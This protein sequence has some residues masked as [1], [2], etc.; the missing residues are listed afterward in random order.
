VVIVAAHAAFVIGVDTHKHTH[1]AAILDRGGRIR[2]QLEVTTD[3]AGLTRLLEHAH[4]IAPGPR[5]WAIEQTGSFGAGLTTLL[6]AAGE[7]VVEIDR[8]SRPARKNGAKDD[9]LDAIRAAREALTRAYLATP[10][11]RGTREA[12]RVLLTTRRAAITARTAAICQLKALV[13]TAPA[14]LRESLRGLS[15]P[16]LVRTCARLHVMSRHQPERRATVL[17]LRATARRIAFLTE[18][19]DELHGELG[20]LVRA[21]CPTLLGLPGLGVLTAAQLLVSWSHP[22]RVR[23]EAA[24]AAIA[25]AAPIL[26][27]SGQHTRHRLNRCGDRQLNRALHNI[28]LARMRCD[29]QTRHYVQRRQAEGRTT[30]EIQRCLKRAAARQLFRF[31]EANATPPTPT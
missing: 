3:P 12:M 5:L 16:Q 8:P 9:L 10:R 29:Q 27:S 20:Q 14:P 22:G 15:T 6:L 13:I 24:F 4:T 11:A 1:T 25:G 31:L 18:Q 30:R 23:S 28:I 19:A 21:V 26:A 17:A 7:T 2:S